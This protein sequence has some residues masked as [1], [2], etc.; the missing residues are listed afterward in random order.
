LPDTRLAYLPVIP[1]TTVESFRNAN[2]TFVFD[3]LP[4]NF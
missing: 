4:A 1:G 3:D 2:Y